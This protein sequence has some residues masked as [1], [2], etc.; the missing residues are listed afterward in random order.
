MK[1]I[2]C[3][4]VLLV[5][6]TLT[7]SANTS[8][9]TDANGNYVSDEEVTEQLGNSIMD[10]ATRMANQMLPI[11]EKLKTCSKANNEYF[12]IFGIENKK[13]H[14]QYVNYNCYLPMDITIQYSNN[15]IKSMKNILLKG[16][17]STS[18][19]E[20]LFIDSILK[21]QQYCN[22]EEMEYVIEY[23]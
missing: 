9:W 23:N 6:S 20:A 17:L 8:Y 18:S 3:T 16:N 12:E 19:P 21:N 11:Y 14:F 1:K 13:C 10:G 2:L 7:I 5:C 4:F 15:A 22:T